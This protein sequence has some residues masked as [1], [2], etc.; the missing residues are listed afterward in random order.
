LTLTFDTCQPRDVSSLTHFETEKP[1][2]GVR[3]SRGS[4]V[5]GKGNQEHGGGQVRIDQPTGSVKHLRLAVFDEVFEPR[6]LRQQ[7]AVHRLRQSV[8]PGWRIPANSVT[9]VV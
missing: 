4:W 8:K 9:K 5:T 6:E 7:N 2:A 3:R 1:R